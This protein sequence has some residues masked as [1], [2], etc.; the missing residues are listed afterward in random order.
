[1]ANSDSLLYDEEFTSYLKQY[2][3][4]FRLLDLSRLDTLFKLLSLHMPQT[5]FYH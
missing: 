2:P 5:A 1:V 4:N 3:D